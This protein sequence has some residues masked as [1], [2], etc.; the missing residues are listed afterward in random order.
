MSM[1]K[2]KT[3]S[4]PKAKTIQPT[5]ELFHVEIE[6]IWRDHENNFEHKSTKILFKGKDKADT[7][8]YI[9]YFNLKWGMVDCIHAGE[10]WGNTNN[11]PDLDD[12]LTDG[13][14]VEEAGELL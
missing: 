3:K 10:G 1:T 2:T 5:A 14:V 6:V 4:K 8:Q 9:K 13:V 7:Y 12:P 11:K